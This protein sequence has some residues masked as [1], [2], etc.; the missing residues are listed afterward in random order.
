MTMVLPFALVIAVGCGYL[1]L[2]LSIYTASYSPYL[3]HVSGA[4]A[5]VLCSRR[6]VTMATA[7]HFVLTMMTVTAT[8]S[9]RPLRQQWDPGIPNS[10]K[11]ISIDVDLTMLPIAPGDGIDR[12]PAPLHASIWVQAKATL[13]VPTKPTI[14]STVATVYPTPMTTVRLTWEEATMARPL[15]LAQETTMAQYPTMAI[16]S[17]RWSQD[18]DPMFDPSPTMLLLLPPVDRS[19]SCCCLPSPTHDA[20]TLSTTE[21]SLATHNPNP[22]FHYSHPVLSWPTVPVG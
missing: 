17:R 14:S 15:F 1:F 13:A 21:P 2:F 4:K 5:T 6:C 3:Q 9:V 20:Q 18:V 22:L 16:A 7:R 8:M 12:P 11:S 10:S 19:S